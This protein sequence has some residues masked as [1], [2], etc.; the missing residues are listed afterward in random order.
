MEYRTNSPFDVLVEQ[1]KLSDESG[2][3]TDEEDMLRDMLREAMDT[4][5][6]TPDFFDT[7]NDAPEFDALAEERKGNP[8]LKLLGSLRGKPTRSVSYCNAT[9]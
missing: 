1:A 9:M 3:D 2:Y 6:A 7:K 4:A 8:F 5:M